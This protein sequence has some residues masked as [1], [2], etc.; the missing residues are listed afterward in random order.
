MFDW[1]LSY[2][3]LKVVSNYLFWCYTEYIIRSSFAIPVQK[4]CEDSHDSSSY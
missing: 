3:A 1:M 4:T 2:K